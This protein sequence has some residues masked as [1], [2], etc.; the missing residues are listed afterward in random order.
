MHNNYYYLCIPSVSSALK[1]LG[2]SIGYLLHCCSLLHV[3]RLHA[4]ELHQAPA[5]EALQKYSLQVSL[6]LAF[7]LAPQQQSAQ[8]FEIFKSLPRNTASPS[9]QTTPKMIAV[10]MYLSRSAQRVYSH[11][12][13]Q[14][15]GA[16]GLADPGESVSAQSRLQVLLDLCLPQQGGHETLCNELINMRIIPSV[17]YFHVDILRL[18]RFSNLRVKDSDL[19]V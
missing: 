18:L 3:V 1:H 13:D 6:R 10:Q 19:E 15:W 16:N 4:Q 5:D 2:S 14:G 9:R 7:P 17:R 8:V 12:S 11:A